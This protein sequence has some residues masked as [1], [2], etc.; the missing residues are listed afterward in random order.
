MKQILIIDCDIPFCESLSVYLHTEGFDAFAVHDGGEGLKQALH[1]DYVLALVYLAM[2]FM[3]GFEILRGIRSRSNMPVLVMTGCGKDEERI[4]GLEM[5]ADDC[6]SKPFNFRELAAR[7]RA[8]LRRTKESSLEMV[9]PPGP[10][11]TVVGDI[12][13]HSG[14]RIAYR[15]GKPIDLTSVEFSVLEMLL[16]YAGRVISREELARGAL[17]R[18]LGANDRSIDVHISSL[19]R[20]LGQHFSGVE[21][22]RTVRNWGY[23]YALLHQPIR[24][25]TN[26][27]Q[28][29]CR[30]GC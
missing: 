12:S 7:I 2:P 1:G 20:K 19:R 10:D 26:T 15:E 27:N 14:I 28:N 17:G 23:L 3:N 8:V 18:S 22:I 6:L 25:E 30:M 24:V 11:R 5:G 13:I 29:L 4:E 21:R 16:R 9:L